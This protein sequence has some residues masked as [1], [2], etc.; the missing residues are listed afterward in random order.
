M[1]LITLV[2]LVF[3][4]VNSFVEVVVTLSGVMV[5]VRRAVCVGTVIV[6]NGPTS[7]TKTEVCVSCTVEIGYSVDTTVTVGVYELVT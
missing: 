3:V 4:L 5:F 6:V 1:V 7:V 2:K